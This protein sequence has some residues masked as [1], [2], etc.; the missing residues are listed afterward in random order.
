MARALSRSRMS[1]STLRT[2]TS[3]IELLPDLYSYHYE[4]IQMGNG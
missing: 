1:S 3:G 4:S 2:N